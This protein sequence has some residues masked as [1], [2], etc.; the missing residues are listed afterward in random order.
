MH[1]PYR[2]ELRR[3]I[4]RSIRSHLRNSDS[5]MLREDRK[6]LHMSRISHFLLFRAYAVTYCEFDESDNIIDRS[7][8]IVATWH[9][10]LFTRPPAQSMVTKT[11][12]ISTINDDR[13]IS[14]SGDDQSKAF[15]ARMRDIYRLDRLGLLYADE[16]DLHQIN[17]ALN[18]WEVVN[19]V[20]MP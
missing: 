9:Y 19:E 13:E 2:H 17:E 18:T 5:A 11:V 1:F 16:H 8:P 14:Y 10:Y 3:S 4:V 12:S 20:D 7:N 6:A 15:G